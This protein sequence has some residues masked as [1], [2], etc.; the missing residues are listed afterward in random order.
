MKIKDLM[1]AQKSIII[2]VVSLTVLFSTSPITLALDVFDDQTPL[3]VLQQAATNG[4]PNAQFVLAIRLINGQVRSQAEQRALN[5]SIQELETVWG[6]GWETFASPP[7]GSTSTMLYSN[8]ELS[9]DEPTE[10]SAL[11]WKAN[12]LQKRTN[13]LNL[14]TF[15]EKK[16]STEATN[17][18][19]A[20]MAKRNTDAMLFLAY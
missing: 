5:D 8:I 12:F 17:L 7:D 1:K 18:L 9:T 2:V 19:E 10:A 20:S 4:N 13:Y 16:E 15:I 11:A 6:S 14:L 3:D